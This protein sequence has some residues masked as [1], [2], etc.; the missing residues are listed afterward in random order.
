MF[1]ASLGGPIRRRP[2]RLPPLSFRLP[3]LVLLALVLT[4]ATAAAQ[5]P[6]PIVVADPLSGKFSE[7]PSKIAFRDTEF[8]KLR[9]RGWRSNVAVARGRNRV[10]VCRPSC[11]EGHVTHVGTTVTVSK[12]IT[13]EGGLQYSCLT[14]R[15]DRRIDPG[16][17]RGNSL[18]PVTFQRCSPPPGTGSAGC[19]G[20]ELG[21]TTALVSVRN[22][23]CTR[24]LSV[25]NAWF[26]TPG[27]APPP[28][29][30][31]VRGFSCS[32]GGSDALLTLKCKRGRRVATARWVG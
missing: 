18:D 28:S 2:L 16:L 19:A 21:F 4:T 26:K 25:L 29:R 10:L 24:G 15:D 11:A 27:K 7:R 6:P 9:W 14:W 17:P 23:G 3:A 32:F 31:R 20:I 13:R 1:R 30:I 8:S 5:E 12:P 22:T